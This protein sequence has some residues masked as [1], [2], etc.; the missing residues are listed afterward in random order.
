MKP[1][2]FSNFKDGIQHYMNVQ[3]FARVAGKI[4]G[5]HA[6]QEKQGRSTE[7]NNAIQYYLREKEILLGMMKECLDKSIVVEVVE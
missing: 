6:L 3:Q 2:R 1:R 7:I 4:E 5:L